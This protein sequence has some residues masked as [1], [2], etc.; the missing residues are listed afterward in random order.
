MIFSSEMTTFQ[1]YSSFPVNEGTHTSVR[2]DNIMISDGILT[3]GG[4]YF[5][6]LMGERIDESSE[7]LS[8]HEIIALP[9]LKLDADAE[10]L[11]WY[12]TPDFSG[13]PVTSLDGLN[14]G[15]VL[16]A[17]TFSH[18][19]RITYVTDGGVI[20]D[21]DYP[22]HFLDSEGLSADQLPKTVTRTHSTFIGWYL[23]EGFT[24]KAGDIPAGAT[25]GVTLYARYATTLSA[26]SFNTSAGANDGLKGSLGLVAYDTHGNAESFTRWIAPS[27]ENGNNGYV[28]IAYDGTNGAD[29]AFTSYG[30]H[31]NGSGY[32]APMG[33]CLTF[34]FR[35]RMSEDGACNLKLRVRGASSGEIWIFEI[36][37]NGTLCTTDANHVIGQASTDAWTA[38]TI[39]LTE[40]DGGRIGVRGYVDGGE[41]IEST[42]TP[43]AAIDTLAEMTRYQFYAWKTAGEDGKIPTVYLDDITLIDGV[44]AE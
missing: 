22:M 10:L 33:N 28:E 2:L 27:E 14:A 20:G 41:A 7:Y 9:D 31:A 40:L 4:K 29:K 43:T 6:N 15:T 37:S 3:V 1:F 16:Y 11:G 44:T 38:V 18:I 42:V 26:F 25:E 39:E 5:L 24:Q 35:I 13:S 8:G 36:K 30:Q 23:D 17:R 32:G 12:L 34:R 19:K 21:T